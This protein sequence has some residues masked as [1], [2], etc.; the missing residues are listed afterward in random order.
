MKRSAFTL[1]ELLVVIAII[2][3]LAAI[4][5]PVFAQAKNA[6][7]KTADL[8]NVRQ[9]GVAI[10]MYANDNDDRSVVKDE[11]LG[12]SWYPSL[13][14]YV[15]SR[16]LFRTPAYKAGLNEPGTDYLINGV[17]AHG[18]TLGAS[19]EPASQIIIALRQR[20]VEDDDYHPW[21]GDYQSWDDPDAYVGEHDGELE[22]WFDER[23]FQTAFTGGSNYAF[24]DGH[25]KFYRFER[26]LANRLYPGMHNVDR[27]VGVYQ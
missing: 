22:N 24:T 10:Q 5:F 27:V 21:P 23:I 2:A 26:T 6:A 9:I 19:S 25:A 7:K 1:I 13:Y 3:I 15:K 18:A 12:I 16:D 14:P 4:L 20:E 8:S 11:E 17:Y